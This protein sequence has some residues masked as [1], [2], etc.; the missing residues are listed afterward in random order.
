MNNLSDRGTLRGTLQRNSGNYNDLIN[1]PAINGH[2]LIGNQSGHALGLANEDDII[3][4]E[5][6][7]LGPATADLHKILVD[8]TIYSIPDVVVY[9]T[10]SGAIA[11]FDDGG[12]NKPLKSLKVAINPV[13][14]GSGEPSPQNVRPISGWS[15]VNVHNYK[16]YQICKA[17]DSSY[18]SN[19]LTITYEGKGKYSVKG[20]MTTNASTTLN[21]NFTEF[22]VY[23]GEDSYIAL[24]NTFSYTSLYLYLRY[25]TTNI[26]QW[27]FTT[28]YRISSYTGM[29]GE[30][31]NN[32][33]L[34]VPN[35]LY[36]TDIDFTFKIELYSNDNKYIYPI[37]WSEAGE[38][39]G[40]YIDYER[41]KLVVNRAE[42][43]I[44]STR[45]LTQNGADII[46]MNVSSKYQK[47]VI[48]LCECFEGITKG[49]SSGL[50]VNQCRF[51]NSLSA[52]NF[53]FSANK[54]V[55][56]WKAELANNPIQLILGLVE[57]IEFDLDEP[58]PTIT[59][60]LGDNNIWSDTGEILECVYQRDINIALNKALNQ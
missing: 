42:Y 12:D 51:N 30:A 35:L 29:R 28:N 52:I 19:G 16:V 55:D 33:T 23:A 8:D 7:P 11:S 58:I 15:A 44:I 24:N 18:T 14:S 21:I 10:T 43:N 1:K 5:A 17:T 53:R 49:Y 26:E 41:K 32:L 54:T 48:P 9:G 37:T 2:T 13:Q 25:G 56:E 31:I 20:R 36:G 45:N 27:G 50:S 3:Y 4:V 34:V 60:L 39:F 40:G 22:N 38:V 6:N 47:D 46:A 57:P 59:T